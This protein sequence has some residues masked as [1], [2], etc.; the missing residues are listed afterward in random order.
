VNVSAK[1]PEVAHGEIRSEHW[2]EGRKAKVRV[3]IRHTI[4]H[5][6]FHRSPTNGARTMC[7]RGKKAFLASVQSMGGPLEVTLVRLSFGD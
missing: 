2:Q 7:S 3:G 5:I 4:F 1:T 6:S